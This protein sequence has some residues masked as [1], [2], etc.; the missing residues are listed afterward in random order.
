MALFDGSNAPVIKAYLDTGNRN[1]GKFILNYSLLGGTDVLGAYTPFSI[2]TKLNINDVR[3]LTIRRGRTREDQQFQPGQ[4]TL[5]LDN[6]SG[7]YDPEYVLTATVTSASGSGTTVTYTASNSFTVGQIVSVTGLSVSALN[8]QC[9]TIVSASSTQFTVSNAATG[10]VSGASGAARTGYVN[11]LG[12]TMLTSNSGIRITATWGGT[13]YSLYS[14][15][16]ETMDKDLG[17][18]PSVTITCTDALAQLGKRTALVATNGLLDFDAI[19]KIVTTVNNNL[20]VSGMPSPFGNY[21][22]S[23]VP[24]DTTALE[25]CSTIAN[26]QLGRFFCN[27]SND[28]VFIKGGYTNTSPAT[29]MLLT[30]DRTVSNAIEY[31]DISIIGGEKYLLNTVNVTNTFAD[32]TTYTVT[33]IND[34]S[35]GRFGPVPVDVNYYFAYSG[36]V[37]TFAQTYADHF[38]NPAYRVNQVGFDALGLSS[39]T[40]VSILTSDLGSPVTVKRTPVYMS[41]LTYLS[42]I[43]ELNHDITPTSWRVSMTLSPQ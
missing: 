13:E 4:L 25:M 8:L 15:Y 1:Q 30:D 21:Y 14:G 23:N 7:N 31:D 37:D 11:Q 41:E 24:T 29:P 27:P 9:Q 2:L 20:S 43:E 28:F 10:S 12:Q 33:K 18:S 3:Q 39:T 6:R 34:V 40:W 35:S 17:L 32:A 19:N 16:I 26:N 36:D 42:V 38:A 5:T 22:L